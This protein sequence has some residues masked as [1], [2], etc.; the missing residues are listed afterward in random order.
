MPLYGSS[1]KCKYLGYF[2]LFLIV[3]ITLKLIVFLK[4]ISQYFNFTGFVLFV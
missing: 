2:A 1:G 3:F 4:K